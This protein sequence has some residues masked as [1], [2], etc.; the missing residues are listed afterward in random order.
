M[1][2]GAFALAIIAFTIIFQLSKKQ[3]SS[4]DDSKSMT[5]H[6]AAG[7][8]LLGQGRFH[9]AIRELDEAVA[10][11]EKNP[12]ALSALDRKTLIQLHREGHLFA[13]LLNEP[14]EDILFQATAELD[15]REWQAV[16]SDRYKG[17]SFIILA[18]T[19]RDNSNH[20]LLDYDVF[21]RDKRARI[22]WENLHLLRDLHLDQPQRL[23][24]GAR[25]ANVEPEAGGT[26]VIRL[27]PDSGVLVTDAEAFSTVFSLPPEGW[28][29]VIKR[30][31]AWV[32]EMP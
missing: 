16:F 17:K 13:D 18:G 1:L 12:N 6:F 14:L 15:E 4:S 30:Q 8:K 26:W 20:W 10:I 29:P 31:A 24:L 2:V 25:L 32:A 28:E 5:E 21:V 7:K 11:R 23:L 9:D 19:R 22:D 3:S 27:E